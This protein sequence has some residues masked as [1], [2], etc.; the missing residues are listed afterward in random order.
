[1]TNSRNIIHTVTERKRRI[2]VVDDEMINREILGEY[3]NQ[4]YEVLFACDGAEAMEV[5]RTNKDTLSLV[6]LDLLMPV[7]SG[8]EVLTRVREDP[9]LAGIPVIV[10]TSDQESEVECLKLGAI[11]FIP[12]PY[13]QPD[14]VLARV[15]RTIELSEDKV[16]ISST[17]R[18]S[19]TGLYNK[20]F[21]YQYAEQMDIHNRETEMDA[22]MIDVSHFHLINERYGKEYG[23]TVLRRI[24]ERIL[25]KLRET[26]GIACRKEADTFLIYS[27][28]RSDYKEVLDELSS[29]LS[30][31]AD[32]ENRIRLRMGV[33][34]CVDKTVDM[35]RRFD[36]AKVAADTVRGSFTKT[37][38][39]YDDTMREKEIYAEQLIEDFP[40]AIEENQFLV[41][42]QPKYDVR[43]ARPVL[44]SAEALVRWQHPE[45]GMISPGV[46][47][48]LFEDNGLI[49]RLDLY[50]WREAARQIREWRDKL[51][52]A[53]PVS[54]N[55][56]RIDLYDPDLLPTLQQ[57]LADN[58]LAPDEL[59]LEITESAYTQDSQQIIAT[60]T[61]LR[62]VG[63]QIE[64][65]DFGTGYSSLNMLSTLPIDAL[66][67]D[68]QFIRNAFKEGGNTRMLEVIID[69]AAYISVP[70][71][72]EGVETED[73]MRALK[74]MGCDL[75]QGYYF[76]KPLPPAD[77]EPFLLEGRKVRA[78]LEAS[79]KEE[80]E[81]A[82]KQKLDA[83]LKERTESTGHP[84]TELSEQIQRRPEQGERRKQEEKGI[85]L[86]VMNVIFTII[87]I[88][89][90]AALFYSDSMVNRGFSRLEEASDRYIAAQQGASNMEIG[91]DYLTDRVRSFVFTGNIQYMKDFFE[92]IEV[93]Q[94]RE[95]ALAGLEALLE[96]NGASAYESLAEALRL[97]NELVLRENLAM[98]LTVE[99]GDYDEA[100][101][102][103]VIADMEL[104]EQ[105]RN[106]S[107]EEKIRKAEELVFDD[108]YIGHK[109]QIRANVKKCT[110]NLLL[111][112]R[113]ELDRASVRMS[114]LLR[115]QSIMT[116]L[117][118]VVVLV[119]VA[120]ISSQVR[121]PL[122][123]MVAQMRAQHPV[124]PTG[125]E[126]LRFVTRTYNEILLENKKA[127]AQLSYDASH[128]ALTGLYNRGAYEML[129]RSVD[130]DHI[131]LIM[132]DVDSFKT[133]NDTYGHDVG[134]QV[135]KRVADILRHSFR[136]VDVIC[137]IGG[138]EFI[139]IMTR[140][141]SSMNQIVQNKISQ[142]NRLLQNP[143]D[144][145]P[146]ASLSV[147]VAFSD[148]KNPQGDIFKDADLA[149]YEAKNAGKGRCKIYGS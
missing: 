5:I 104:D 38:G 137:R 40:R 27:P 142:A 93:T 129:L 115:T 138:D 106:M 79:R 49:Q 143:K 19:L 145:I 131:A 39:I 111:S 15:L 123:Q 23:D 75:V 4:D 66:K 128:D 44:Y 130:L 119:Q 125:A 91:S 97:S 3:L 45:L 52:F 68:M 135:L 82:E 37:I 47:I 139:V 9:E 62:A 13:P 132:V 12:K 92:E 87:A 76:S 89:A 109:E 103:A 29:G 67:L 107:R 116:A 33:Y 30:G 77:F 26:G 57:I 43:P 51:G 105:Y 70:V 60:V 53:V 80:K 141:N 73:Q 149:L 117:M 6:L 61:A 100:D 98:R 85:P 120:F 24:A 11:D 69:I 54:V 41:Y 65:D 59:K 86:R 16:I 32:S 101:I 63:F 71:I 55:V 118:L 136:S 99:A 46:F 17:E 34:S 72:A 102:P 126:E 148:R 134:D 74:T 18:D 96:G 108:Y 7:M 42:Y 124:S 113:D 1:M 146:P 144:G 20:E 95:Q 83:I 112:S 22:V 48:P 50:V 94:R 31:N 114:S 8:K 28:H 64:M 25:E 88:I 127:H 21:F 78:E 81:T 2:L 121:K 58:G 56:S 90:A 147:G 36:R 140:A 14:V 35:E 84:V 133:I 122:T 110:E 10:I